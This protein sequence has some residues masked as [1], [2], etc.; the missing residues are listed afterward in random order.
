MPIA[1]LLPFDRI[2]LQCEVVCHYNCIPRV[3]N[4]CF[5]LSLIKK[6]HEIFFQKFSHKIIM[7]RIYF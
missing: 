1:V 3:S 4:S 2:N 6:I 7:I 5:F